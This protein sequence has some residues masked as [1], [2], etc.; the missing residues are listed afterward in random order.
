M[1]V[2][3]LPTSVSAVLGLGTN[4]APG[5][6]AAASVPRRPRSRQT[7]VLGIVIDRGPEVPVVETTLPPQTIP[8]TT[9]TEAAEPV[10]APNRDVE[11]GIGPLAISLPSEPI[12]AARQAAPTT[13]VILL[14]TVLAGC[15]VVAARELRRQ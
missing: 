7:R 4:P 6:A 1:P 10:V 13:V 14:T 11:M 15:V 12:S 9:T 3:P 5:P 2:G 8:T